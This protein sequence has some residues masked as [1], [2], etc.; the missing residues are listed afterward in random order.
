MRLITAFAIAALPFVAVAQNADS[1]AACKSNSTEFEARLAAC[2]NL[3]RSGEYLDQAW[4]LERRG[5]AYA[6]NDQYPEAIVDFQASLEIDP[7]F[8]PALRGL[9]IA[10]LELENP[11]AAQEHAEKLIEIAPDNY[12]HQHWFAQTLEG[13]DKP[14]DAIKAFETSIGLKSDW[15]FSHRE[16]GYLLND[17]RRNDDAIVALET[18]RDLRP[19]STAPYRQLALAHWREDRISAAALNS[20]IAIALTQTSTNFPLS[21]PNFPNRLKTR[22]CHR[23][24]M[25]RRLTAPQ[26][27]WWSG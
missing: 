8:I 25:L 17:L 11:Q 2:N 21:C 18:A 7:E 22:L 5:D 3:W 20:R 16:L 14:E 13:L 23:L 26:S 1:E 19:F 12:F 15:Y 6:D 10:H 4:V 24:P 27:T 9:V